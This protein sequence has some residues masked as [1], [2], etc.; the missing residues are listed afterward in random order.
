MKK[1]ILSLFIALATLSCTNAQEHEKGKS[2]QVPAAVDN[3][4]SQKFKS[5]KPVWEKEGNDYEANFTYEGKETSAVFTATGTWLETETEIP[6]SELPATAKGY[7]QKNYKDVA[8]KEAAKIIHA[9]GKINYEAEVKS[10][11]LIFDAS[12]NFIKQEN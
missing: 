3:A 7:I 2:I 12:G 10:K 5:T 4:F 6:V 11:D 1:P 9:D 8:I